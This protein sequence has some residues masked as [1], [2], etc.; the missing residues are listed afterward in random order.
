MKLRKILIINVCLYFLIYSLWLIIS[1]QDFLDLLRV[2]TKE[3][4]ITHRWSFSKQ[5]TK[6]IF[7]AVVYLLI[8]LFSLLLSMQSYPSTTEIKMM[9]LITL[10]FQFFANFLQ[11]SNILIKY[12]TSLNNPKYFVFIDL[13]SDIIFPSTFIVISLIISINYILYIVKEN[14]NDLQNHN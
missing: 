8:F 13:I 3:L 7:F 2:I 6:A 10:M 9:I 12:I 11:L 5:V 4:T 14:K 1:S